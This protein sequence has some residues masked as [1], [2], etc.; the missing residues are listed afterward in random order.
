[1]E[2]FRKKE[3]EGKA[4][5]SLVVIGESFFREIETRSF[6]SLLRESIQTGPRSLFSF[7]FL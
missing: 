6:S 4:E 7:L 2:E 1:M 3:R 5:L